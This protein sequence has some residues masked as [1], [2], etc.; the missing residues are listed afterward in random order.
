VR[1]TRWHQ[2]I[3]PNIIIMAIALIA[4][5]NGLQFGKVFFPVDVL[6][7]YP[8]WHPPAQHD[9]IVK[10]PLLRDPVV[11]FH[12]WE[13]LIRT[14]I[15]QGRWPLWNPGSFMGTPLLG[16]GQI[17]AFTIFALPL[18]LLSPIPAYFLSALLKL[19]VAGLCMYY[20]GR[21]RALGRTAS[22]VSGIVFMFSGHMMAW[23]HFPLS[24]GL[25]L[26]PLLLLA[27]ER[28]LLRT[29]RLWFC[30]MTVSVAM[31]ALCGQ[32]QTSFCVGLLLLA[33]CVYRSAN[34]WRKGPNDGSFC[35]RITWLIA[36]MAGGLVLSSFQSLVFFEYLQVSAAQ[37][38]R[39]A[40]NLFYL[41][42]YQLITLLLPDFFGNVMHGNYWGYANNIGPA[43]YV[44]VLP[45]YLAMTSCVHNRRDP[46]TKFFAGTALICL[47][48][49]TK[50]IGVE[51]VFELPIIS[52]ITINKFIGPF[53]L[54]MAFLAGKGIDLFW[55]R[56]KA[57]LFLCTGLLTLSALCVAS[58]ALYFWRWLVELHLWHY[59]LLRGLPLFA[60]TPLALLALWLWY[61]RSSASIFRKPIPGQR[62]PLIPAAIL[63]AT[64]IVDPLYY[65]LNFNPSVEN[66]YFYPITDGI[67][68]LQ[69]D[70]GVWR[71]MGLGDALLPNTAGMYRLQDSLGYDGMTYRRY[72][73][74]VSLVDP[75]FK[76]LWTAL[77]LEGLA[78]RPWDPRTSLR[79]QSLL[80]LLA[81][82]GTGFRSFL[83]E[84]NYW[85]YTIRSVQNRRLLDLMNVK[86]LVT[87]PS[88]SDQ[89]MVHNFDLVYNKEVRIYLNKTALPRA[90]VLNHWIWAH[91]DKAAMRLMSDPR[92][93][94]AETAILQDLDANS[95][96]AQEFAPT[97][98]STN[99]HDDSA[100]VLS[101]QSEKILLRADVSNESF[102]LLSDVW[103][104][105][106]RCTVD[107]KEAKVFAADYL[108]RGVH[109][110]PG[111]HDVVFFYKP[112]SFA[113]GL[114]LSLLA[115]FGM[116]ASLFFIRDRSRGTGQPTGLR[117][118][119]AQR[120]LTETIN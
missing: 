43:I 74:F 69:K 87:P 112:A 29:S 110:A 72:Y 104:P 15:Y 10:N 54:A 118:D 117:R 115:A 37:A 51:Q 85:N 92:F 24:G 76:D 46:D 78:S 109:L 44:G 35:G 32:P 8:P 22:L 39:N 49:V 26:A 105:G 97:K 42:F 7:D 111:N 81:S 94:P 120:G 108:F 6:S 90:I 106:W 89:G 86:Y 23:L 99:N 75:A 48:I 103:Y 60:L 79:D 13:T 33:Y 36:A 82:N 67:R 100:T 25:A 28:L 55:A 27:A 116:L 12:P 64:I 114:R 5:S 30:I 58:A 4:S 119:G 62:R 57:V 21:A 18:H 70:S 63:V 11:E 77:G 83:K 107:G 88:W 31:L 19:S 93:D 16:N 102:L 80:D 47:L 71:L 14:A 9:S 61:R 52:G 45:L 91:D 84:A 96:T 38:V 113:W 41:P 65:W 73:D 59:E 40:Y 2:N 3:V 98:S 34:V 50:P 53:T 68:F 17:S 66:R 101:Y 20:F 1:G 95:M 56:F